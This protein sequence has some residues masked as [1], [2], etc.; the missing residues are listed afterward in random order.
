M[1]TTIADEVKAAYDVQVE[2]ATNIIAATDSESMRFALSNVEVSTCPDEG[3]VFVAAT[4]ARVIAVVKATGILNDAE[5]VQ[6]PREHIPS[7]KK[8]R[9]H[10]TP[11]AD[12]VGHRWRST[13]SSARDER[14]T[15][16]D[17]AFPKWRDMFSA[18]AE[19]R[20]TSVTLDAALLKDLAEAINPVDADKKHVVTLL[21]SRKRPIACNAIPVLGNFAESSSGFGLL[22]PCVQDNGM[23]SEE[24]SA[25]VALWNASVE[26]LRKK[27]PVKKK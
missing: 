9:K 19:S 25:S 14:R 3:H 6:V 13:V 26:D 7:L 27:S 23:E 12:R 5:S 18:E 11:S 10:C 2:F 15:F 21:V 24:R 22:M 20:V 17:R 4:N 16:E 8:H 1:S